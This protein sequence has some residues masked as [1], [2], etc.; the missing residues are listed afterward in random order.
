MKKMFFGVVVL[1]AFGLAFGQP[2]IADPNPPVDADF[3]FDVPANWPG[4]GCAFPFRLTSLNGKAKTILLPDG[5]I[6]ATSPGLDVTV[7]NLDE[8][9]K[10]VTL[11]VTGA[12]HITTAANGDVVYV[13]TGRNFLTDPLAGV[14]LAKG[15][16][17]FAFDAAGNL[18]QP[19]AGKGTLTDVCELID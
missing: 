6:I 13:V 11:N 17:S 8:P 9:S 2:A 10:Q 16:F 4:G 15:N 14:V 19:L 5:R 1:L 7:T 3:T 12:F 18:I